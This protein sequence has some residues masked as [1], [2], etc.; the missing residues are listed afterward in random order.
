MGFAEDKV[1]DHILRNLSNFGNIHVTSLAHSL[2]CLTEADRD[3]LQA[4]EE[5]RGRHTAVFKLY[6]FLK[7]RRGWV[8]DLI[9]ALH[10]NN[11]G[12]LAEELQQ[13]YDFYRIPGGA[14]SSS[15]SARMP[16]VGANPAPGA[17]RPEQPRREP[18]AGS[19]PSLLPGAATAASSAAASTDLDSR[20]PV[21]ESLPKELPERESPP[22]PGSVARD[23]ASEG[24]RGEGCVPLPPDAARATAELP[25]AATAAMPQA[26]PS[27]HGRDWPSRQQHPVCVDNGYFGNA[28][29]LNRGALRLGS[30]RSLPLGDPSAARRNEPEEVHYVSA[31]LPPRPVEAVHV[32]EPRP[33]DSLKTPACG[34]GPGEPPSSFVDVR[35]PLLIQKEFDAEQKRLGMLRSSG[36]DGDAQVEAAPPVSAPAPTATFTSSGASLKAPVQEGK[37][38]AG[39]RA[40][41]APSIP[42]KERVLPASAA[43]FLGTTAVGS[44][45][46]TA[47]RRTPLVSSAG[48]MQV[49]RTYAEEDVELS[50]PGVLLS[51]AGGNP[52]GASR[53]LSSRWPSSSYSGDSDRLE[54][55]SDSLMLSTDSLSHG[56]A[57][58]RAPLGC[59]TPA[60]VAHADP[61][62]EK[63]TAANPCPPPSTSLVTHEVRVDHYPSVLLGAPQDLPQGDS[64]FRNPPAFDSS[65]N[66]NLSQ[67]KVVPRDSN[68]S[69]WSYIAPAA[70]IALISA[71]AFL[72]YARLQK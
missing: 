10:Q 32:G 58:S 16:S 71:V 47:G 68:S 35:N 21:Q 22:P 56:E 15:V 5:M 48:N 45:E 50:K 3:E 72:V 42:T 27:E 61:A 70:G 9:N 40:G 18:P 23:G 46:G 24:L 69:S 37:L 55:S 2:T 39:E 66:S 26:G 64:P 28:N 17:P 63:A 49:F 14:P 67:A 43:P 53:C 7:C 38:A 11:A 4:R 33:P 19:Q 51:A 34:S 52:E 29:H 30:G 6:Q 13:L 57:L 44:F 62:G 65:T 59:W 1:Y 20:A 60:P 41:S 31:E 54:L 25:G 8:P 12:H 36:G